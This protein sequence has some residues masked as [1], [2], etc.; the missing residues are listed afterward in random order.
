MRKRY[1]MKDKHITLLSLFLLHTTVAKLR[2]ISAPSDQSVTCAAL[3][4]VTLNNETNF[5]THFC[6]LHRTCPKNIT[7]LSL[8]LD[9]RW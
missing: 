1:Q 7:L 2:S 6:L 8:I 3:T 5:T 4:A 9:A